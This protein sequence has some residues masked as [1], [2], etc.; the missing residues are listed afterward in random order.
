MLATVLTAITSFISTNIDDIFLL[1]LFFVQAESAKSKRCVVIGQYLGMG[2]LTAVSLLGSAALQVIPTEYIRFLGVIPIVL[3]IKE[4]IKYRKGEEAE[5]TDAPQIKNSAMQQILSITLI[6]IANGADNIGV[7]VP[8]FAG[9]SQKQMLLAVIVFAC[10]T[11]LLC[12][13]GQKFAS[14]PML[15]AGIQ[16][17]KHILVPILFVALGIYILLA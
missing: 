6:C 3:G 2:I 11:A 15:Q 5:E 14:L 9:Y 4:W 12:F 1:M 8:L 16:K 13:L 7:Y 17:Y 10:M